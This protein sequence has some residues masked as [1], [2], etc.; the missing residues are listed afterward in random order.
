MNF[1]KN[2]IKKM[3]FIKIY[4]LVFLLK[5]KIMYWFI[6]GRVCFIFFERELELVLRL[7]I[8]KLWFLL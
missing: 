3:D 2:L 7:K 8:I 1:I 5:K 4:V 6:G